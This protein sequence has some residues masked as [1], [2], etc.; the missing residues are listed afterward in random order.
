M[1][2]IAECTIHDNIANLFESSG[3]IH[4]ITGEY[5]LKAKTRTT[6]P[7]DFAEF[8]DDT[9]AELLACG[10]ARLPTPHESALRELSERGVG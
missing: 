5:K 1:L 7:G 2:L 6:N 3:E 4:P 10:A 9:A 8:P